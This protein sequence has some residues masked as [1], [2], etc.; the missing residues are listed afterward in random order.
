MTDE[1]RTLKSGGEG[2]YTEKRSKF[3]AF[4]H[5][6][7]TVDEIKE[8]LS[9]Y[10]KKYFD[11][12]HVC[13][14]YMLG[15]ERTE[16]RAN[17]DGEPSSTAGK[18]ILGQINSNELTDILIVVVRY[19]GGV[20]LGTGGLIVAYREAAQDAMAHSEIVEQLVEEQLT[21][22]FSYPMMNSVMRVVKDL[23]P[24]IVSQNFD[25]TCSITLAIRKSE[26]ERLRSAL[27]KLNFE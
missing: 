19:Y 16:F 11:A 13:Y 25:N 14:A 21:Y 23:Q 18:P 1:Y 2:Y 26:I 20:N 7:S 12:R 3:L 6:V 15:P 22:T 24:R 17:D 27:E 8:I 9:G 5:H 10:R 4:A